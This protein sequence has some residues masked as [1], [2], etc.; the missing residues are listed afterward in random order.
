MA[1]KINTS[2][3]LDREQLKKLDIMNKKT[4]VPKAEYIREALEDLFKKYEKIIKEKKNSPSSKVLILK[5][6]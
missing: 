1:P 5:K 4:R 3:Y 6:S 2:I